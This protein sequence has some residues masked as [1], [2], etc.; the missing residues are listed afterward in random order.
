MIGFFAQEE[1]DLVR[2]YQDAGAGIEGKGARTHAVSIGILYQRGLAGLL[3]DRVNGDGVFASYEHLL[4]LVI[5]GVAGAV[6]LVNETSVGMHVNSGSLLPGVNVSGVSQAVFSKEGDGI[7]CSVRQLL[8]H[9]EL[10]LPL[11]RN[12]DPRLGGMKIQ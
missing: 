4:A 7:E 1:R 8:I 2:G 6:P 5:D 3:I 9:L 10:A 11:Q 12:E